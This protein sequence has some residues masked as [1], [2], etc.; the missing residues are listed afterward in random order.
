MTTV[1]DNRR[2]SGHSSG[3]NAGD[4]LTLITTVC[5]QTSVVCVMAMAVCITCERPRLGD[6]NGG[7][8]QIMC[9]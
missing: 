2:D 7:S 6:A 8:E 9:K 1:G 5:F 3:D 4:T